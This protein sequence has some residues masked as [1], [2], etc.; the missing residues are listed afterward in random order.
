M[1]VG[2]AGGGV[3]GISLCKEEPP[4]IGRSSSKLEARVKIM[5]RRRYNENTTPHCVRRDGE[6]F[7]EGRN[8]TDAT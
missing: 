5:Q 6:A 4:L 3:P 7:G 8:V 1:H 2:L